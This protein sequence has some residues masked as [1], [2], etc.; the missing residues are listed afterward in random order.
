MS[1]SKDNKINQ[2]LP[3]FGAASQPVIHFNHRPTASPPLPVP[4]PRF[5]SVCAAS[6]RGYLRITPGIRKRVIAKFLDFL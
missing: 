4:P 5:V 3:S 2:L 1:K 6:V